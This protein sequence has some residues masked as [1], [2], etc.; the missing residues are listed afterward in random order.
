[1]RGVL[2]TWA[3]AWPTITALLFALD[4]VLGHWPLALRTLV[5]TGLMVPAMTVV[6]V[7]ALNR[8]LAHF[9]KNYRKRCHADT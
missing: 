7:P 3:A 8:L 4:G 9:S 1:M 6:I 2:V 5:L